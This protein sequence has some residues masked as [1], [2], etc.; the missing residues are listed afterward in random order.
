M[1]VNKVIETLSLSPT[2]MFIKEGMGQ[3]ICDA[4]ETT[5]ENNWEQG[6]K[7]C[8]VVVFRLVII[9]TSA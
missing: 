3:V 5:V 7:V 9:I 1:R 2:D 4:T 8:D 6:P